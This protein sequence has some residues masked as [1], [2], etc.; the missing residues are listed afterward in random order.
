MRKSDAL[1][2]GCSAYNRC[3]SHNRGALMRSAPI[4]AALLAFVPAAMAAQSRGELVRPR[5]RASTTSGTAT[6]SRQRRFVEL[7]RARQPRAEVRNLNPIL[8]E[9][10]SIKSAREIAMLRRASQIAG[11]GDDGSDAQH[12]SRASPSISST[13]RRATSSSSTTRVSR[14]IAR[15]RRAAPRTSTTCT[16]SA[17]RPRSRTATW[18]SWTTRRT[19]ATTR[20]T[21]DGCGRSTG[22]TRP[23]SGSSCSSSSSTATPS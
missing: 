5:P 22:S 23:G 18:C 7:L 19:T 17:T 8:D 1:I 21:S 11:L 16:T 15:S 12:R 3:T 2:T 10:R 14:A 6:V 13:R 4:A 20:A 9:M